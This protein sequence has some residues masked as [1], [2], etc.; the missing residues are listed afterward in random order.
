[1]TT[2]AVLITIAYLILIGYLIVGFDKIKN[3]QKS[4]VWEI[5]SKKNQ[6]KRKSMIFY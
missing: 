2:I 6:L 3:V 4:V 5:S 1:M